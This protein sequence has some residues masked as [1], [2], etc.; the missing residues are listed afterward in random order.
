MA[1]NLVVIASNQ[2]AMAC[3]LVVIASSL[4]SDGPPRSDGLQPGTDGFQPPNDGPPT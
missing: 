2:L 4:P 1:S 3:H